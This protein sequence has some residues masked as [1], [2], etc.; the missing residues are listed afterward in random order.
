MNDYIVERTGIHMIIEMKNLRVNAT[1]NSWPTLILGYVERKHKNGVQNFQGWKTCE[2]WRKDT[3]KKLDWIFFQIAFWFVYKRKFNLLN[4][5]IYRFGWNSTWSLKKKKIQALHVR[6][7][8][9]TIIFFSRYFIASI[10]Q[11][12]HKTRWIL[13]P[14]HKL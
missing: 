12:Y 9:I 3:K 6:K 4:W 5:K 8:S 13:M 14:F 7:N 2:S 1:A 10:I 11:R